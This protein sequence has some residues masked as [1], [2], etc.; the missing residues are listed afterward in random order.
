MISCLWVALGGAI[1]SVA[2]YLIGLIKLNESVVFPY[3]TLIINIV[4][5]F[6]IGLITALSLS[7][8]NMNPDM[9]LFLKVGICGGFTTFSTFALE[10]S[11]LF[12][13]GRIGTAILYI[14]L[15]LTLSI[16]AAF[17]AQ[18]IVHA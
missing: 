10:S 17:A 11:N 4:G 16:V 5:S 3:K 7:K 12:Q 6:L 2:R 8:G 18:Q 15:S 1:G 13:G 14:V 9:V